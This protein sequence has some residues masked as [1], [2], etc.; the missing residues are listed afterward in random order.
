MEQPPNAVCVYSS[1]KVK[2]Y[3]ICPIRIEII[4]VRHR[5]VQILHMGWAF[6]FLDF[7]PRFRSLEYKGPAHV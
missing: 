7:T 2:N 6:V 4:H 5:V 1:R 3:R